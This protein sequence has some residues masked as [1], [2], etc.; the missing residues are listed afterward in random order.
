MIIRVA[1][2]VSAGVESEDAP[3]EGA[4]VHYGEWRSNRVTIRDPYS[5][6][7]EQKRTLSYRGHVLWRDI[8]QPPDNDTKRNARLDGDDLIWESRDKWWDVEIGTLEELIAVLN[9]DGKL[10]VDNGEPHIEFED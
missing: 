2:Y 5:W 4:V 9:N 10:Y 1:R 8:A 7:G 6:G 3:C